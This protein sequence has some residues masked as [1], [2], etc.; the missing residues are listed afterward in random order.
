MEKNETS[1]YGN[2]GNSSQQVR[3]KMAPTMEKMILAAMR[4]RTSSRK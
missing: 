1:S 4:R 2:K 3:V